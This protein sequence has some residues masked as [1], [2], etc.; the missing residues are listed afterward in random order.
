MTCW[1]IG[2]WRSRGGGGRGREWLIAGTQPAEI[3]SQGQLQECRSPSHS[4]CAFCSWIQLLPGQYTG[5]H[6]HGRERNRDRKALE[7]CRGS[8]PVAWP[9]WLLTDALHVH[10]VHLLCDRWSSCHHPY[11]PSLILVD[12]IHWRC[13]WWTTFC[14]SLPLLCYWVED[15]RL[16][17]LIA[18][19]R[20]FTCSKKKQHNRKQS[21]ITENLSVCL[22]KAFASFKAQHDSSQNCYDMSWHAMCPHLTT[23]NMFDEIFPHVRAMALCQ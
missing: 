13:L 17:L 14:L 8:S 5:K 4:P 23:L 15:G 6:R 3:L 1:I 18:S 7:H 11:R 12:L 16:V 19:I 10:S 21:A 22:S 20:C 2:E 9:D